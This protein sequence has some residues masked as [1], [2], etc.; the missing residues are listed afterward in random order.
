MHPSAAKLEEALSLARLEESALADEDLDRA[1]ELADKRADLLFDAWSLRKGYAVELLCERLQELQA[2]Q[3]RLNE[4][5]ESLRDRLSNQ[6]SSERKQS[7]YFDGYRH[8]KAQAQ[9]SFYCD[10]RS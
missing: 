6:I 8:A 1:E 9:K 4:R 7:K 10:K 2:V 5:A 3:Q